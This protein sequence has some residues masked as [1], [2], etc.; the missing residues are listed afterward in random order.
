MPSCVQNEIL[1]FTIAE[2]LKGNNKIAVVKLLK[3]HFFN[4][5]K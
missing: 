3:N 1:S 4:I 5:K 2:I